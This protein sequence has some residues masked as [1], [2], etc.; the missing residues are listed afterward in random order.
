MP[1]RRWHKK[2]K[3]WGLALIICALG[4]AATLALNQVIASMI[5]TTNG[6]TGRCWET[7]A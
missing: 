1:W 5:R 3:F 7:R 4:V 2:L 6:W